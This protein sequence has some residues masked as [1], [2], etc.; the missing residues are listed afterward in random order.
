VA[1]ARNR[2][3]SYHFGGRRT[4]RPSLTVK[5]RT[6]GPAPHSAQGRF[7]LTAT[8]TIADY[9]IVPTTLTVLPTSPS[10]STLPVPGPLRS[11][12]SVGHFCRAGPGHF[13]QA[14]KPSVAESR[15]GSQESRSGT[16]A[17]VRGAALRVAHARALRRRPRQGSSAHRES[18]AACR[19][20]S[21][22]PDR[23]RYRP[24]FSLAKMAASFIS[25][26]LPRQENGEDRHRYA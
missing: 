25:R 23:A 18:R 21:T 13:S 5:T 22:P 10:P 9:V 4:P 14:S 1:R 2:Q 15:G 19:R 3:C 16:S 6:A 7:F 11:S 12:G 8:S 24:T 20:R 26:T 17:A